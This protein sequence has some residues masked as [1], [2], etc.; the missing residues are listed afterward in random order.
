MIHRIFV[1]KV[2]QH[3]LHL[4]IHNSKFPNRTLNRIKFTVSI[5]YP[6]D[7]YVDASIIVFCKCFIIICYWMNLLPGQSSPLQQ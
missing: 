7:F 4:A 1:F 3:G 5:V 6:I 2:R